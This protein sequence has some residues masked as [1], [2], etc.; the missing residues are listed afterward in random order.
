[1]SESLKGDYFFGCSDCPW[2]TEDVKMDNKDEFHDL[3]PYC[4]IRKNSRQLVHN[5]TCQEAIE[6][7]N[8][9]LGG[10]SIIGEDEQGNPITSLSEEKVRI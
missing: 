1:M 6:T 10:V 8:D 9:D 2:R 3:L 7:A 5:E 4:F